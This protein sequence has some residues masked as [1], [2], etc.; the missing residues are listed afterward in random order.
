MT[1]TAVMTPAPLRP[2][3]KREQILQSARGVFLDHGYEGAS[4]DAIA[5]EAQVSKATVYAHF[6]DKQALFAEMVAEYCREQQAALA[7]IEAEHPRVQEGL[8]RLARVMMRYLAAPNALRFG[9]MIVGESARFPELGRTFVDSGFLALQADIAGFLG[10]AAERG[11]LDLPDPALAAE[12]F[13]SMVRGPVQFRSLRALGAPP[14]DT[15]LD[16][17]ASEAARLLVTAYARK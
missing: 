3:K 9:R 11:E 17:I 13:V 15:A 12:L 7:E 4:M 1:E 5:A 14:D 10:R 6:A 16:R 8:E 2:S